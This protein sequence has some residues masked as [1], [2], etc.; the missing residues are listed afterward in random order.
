[1]N[2]FVLYTAVF[3][4]VSRFR[5]PTISIPGIDKFCFTDFGIK[6]TFYQMKRMKLDHLDYVRRNRFAKICIPDEIF[7]N[8]EH[9]LYLDYKHPMGIDFDLLENNLGP[10]SDFLISKH[11]HRGCIYDEGRKCID[12]GKGDPGEIL[13]QLATYKKDGY[14]VNN[15]LYAAYWVFRRHTKRLKELMNLWWLEVKAHSE[16]DQISLPYVA[17]KYGMNISLNRKQE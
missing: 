7:D 15:G 16:R 8:Y 6:N 13:K 11:K 14:P 17:W 4:K 10:S 9:S 5:E 1:M 2:K 12:V 3:G